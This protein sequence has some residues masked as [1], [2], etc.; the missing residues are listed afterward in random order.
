MKK[1]VV[2]IVA[3][4]SLA[5]CIKEYSVAGN[6]GPLNTALTSLPLSDTTLI[7]DTSIFY[8]CEFNGSREITIHPLG[9]CNLFQSKYIGFPYDFTSTTLGYDCIFN[10][11][12]TLPG[13]RLEI[14]IRSIDFLPGDITRELRRQKTLYG[15]S[16]AVTF[17]YAPNLNAASSVI[18][19]RYD[20]AGTLWSTNLGTANQTGSCFQLIKSLNLP[21]S[22]YFRC[23]F[24]C[25]LYNSAGQ[26]ILLKN[27]RMGMSI[28][29]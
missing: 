15:L 11:S 8:D 18:V 21:N 9:P 17:N 26:S 13:T 27:G 16:P 12:D 28:W 6:S 1:I 10:T 19:S 4:A 23:T 22:A 2:I 25:T 20:A 5:G 14:K 29:L 3:I 7:G 24:N